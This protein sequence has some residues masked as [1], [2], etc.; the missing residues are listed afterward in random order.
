M[1]SPD[2]IKTLK[3]DKIAMKSKTYAEFLEAVKARRP[4]ARNLG[5]ERSFVFFVDQAWLSFG[6]GSK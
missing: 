1:T 5:V 2:Y 3:L 6:T 4:F